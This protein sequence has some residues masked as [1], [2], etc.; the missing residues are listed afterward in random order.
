VSGFAREVEH[1]QVEV[2]RRISFQP[3]TLVLVVNSAR[4]L[5]AVTAR[6]PARWPRRHIHLNADFSAQTLFGIWLPAH[7]RLRHAVRHLPAMAR[8]LAHWVSARRG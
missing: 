6:S 1:R 3:N 2:V 8:R 4:S 7:V 5:H